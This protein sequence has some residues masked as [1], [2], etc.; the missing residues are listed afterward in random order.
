[1]A[2]GALRT[3]RT[4]RVLYRQTKRMLVRLVA[5]GWHGHRYKLE[6]A[7]RRFLRGRS[8]NEMVRLAT[9]RVNAVALAASVHAS[10]TAGTLRPVAT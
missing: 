9:S 3:I 7:V 8:C 2:A 6:R 5:P 4:R 10:A 1:M